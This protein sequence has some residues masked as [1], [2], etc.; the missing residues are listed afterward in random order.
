M[1]SI[2]QNLFEG[3]HIVLHSID[4]EKDS[5]AEVP[6]TTN[7]DYLMDY[8][9]PV[10]RPQSA[11]ELQELHREH[12]KDMQAKRN[13]FPFGLHEK[14]GDRLIG[15]LRASV[16]VWSHGA[17]RLVVQVGS[18][19]DFARY[20]EEVLRLGLAYIFEE[21]NQFRVTITVPEYNR[22]MIAM[23]DRLGFKR[24]VVRRDAVYRH[25]QYW[26]LYHYG[27]LLEEYTQMSAR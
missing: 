10:Q 20:G 18:P 13:V 17:S 1:I 5:A 2:E 23:L 7:L 15:F 12:L 22:E 16:M 27:L 6:W 19:E 26:D 4:V 11:M 14:A 25:G 8:A 3:E 9:C 21:L 24:E